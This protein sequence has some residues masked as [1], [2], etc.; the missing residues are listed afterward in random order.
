[1]SHVAGLQATDNLATGRGIAGLT[2]V[3]LASTGIAI[4]VS[5]SARIGGRW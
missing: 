3:V 1:V 2:I 4:Y 5:F